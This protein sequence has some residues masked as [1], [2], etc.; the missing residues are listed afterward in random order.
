M[1]R[2]ILITIAL[3]AVVIGAGAR[4]YSVDEI[5]N[6]Q[7]ADHTRYLS[8]P[9]GILSNASRTEID[10][11]LSRV[12]RETSAEV[13]AVI[14]GDIDDDIDIFANRLYNSWGLGKKDNNNGVLIL[15]ARDARK[16]VIRTGRGSEGVLPDIVCAHIMREKMFPAFREGDYDRGMTET[17]SAVAEVITDPDAAAEL[18]SKLKDNY[19]RS[20]VHPFRLYVFFCV[21]LA[22]SCLAALLLKVR[23]VRDKSPYDK[24]TALEGWKAPLLIATAGGL[25]MPLIASLPLLLLLRHWRNSPRKCPNCGHR[26][27]KIDEVHDNDY[28]T[29]AQDAEE[30]IG[31]VDYDVWNC[32]N[33]HETD[34]FPFVNKSMPMTVCEK[35][36]ARTA[37]LTSDR[38]LVQPTVSREGIGCKDYTCVNCHH[39]M[40][41][42]YP[43]AKLPPVIIAPIG[44]GGKGG[45]FGGGSSFGGGFGGGIT[46]GGGSSGGW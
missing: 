41:R 8:D 36:H 42:R 39:V 21:I 6:V 34:I 18:Q 26:M 7:V 2:Y 24:Y 30:R 23:S 9:D 20:D 19:G 25:L 4:T 43:I 35:C 27:I 29:P 44:G 12:R 5:P 3:L 16:A 40:S 37:R 45:G 32:P 31:S 14:V 17:V 38:A 28:L 11:T 15:V 1:K 46:G 10:S 33:C 13:A 22:L